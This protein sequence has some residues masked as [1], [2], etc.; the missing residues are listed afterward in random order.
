MF[1]FI[2]AAFFM[3]NFTVLDSETNQPVPNVQ[4][5]CLLHQEGGTTDKSGLIELELPSGRH[6][7]KISH[8]GYH[9]RIIEIDINQNSNLPTVFLTPRVLPMPGVEVTDKIIDN[10]E[11]SKIDQ[12]AIARK[13]SAGEPDILRSL[14]FMPQIST[15]SDYSPAPAIRGI[16]ANYTQIYLDD[17]PLLNPFHVGGLFSAIDYGIIGRM[18]VYPGIV[19]PEFGETGGGL[20]QLQPRFVT[21]NATQIEQGLISTKVRTL[22]CVNSD[23]QTS[24]SARYFT[25]DLLKRIIRSRSD[26]SFYDLCWLN[27]WKKSDHLSL[28]TI[29]YFSQE[30]LPNSVDQTGDST[31]QVIT[32][33]GYQNILFNLKAKWNASKVAFYGSATPMK[34]KTD[35]NQADNLMA[36]YG[37]KLTH[38]VGLF[39]GYLGIGLSF[40]KTVLNY[41]WHFERSLLNDI[42]GGPP[43]FAF[44]D[45][46]PADFQARYNYSTM[47]LFAN[48]DHE[49]FSKLNLNLGIRLE[50]YQKNIFP[51]PRLSLEYDW[52]SWKFALAY[53]LVY[54]FLYSLK[55]KSNFE[56]YTP[57]SIR[58][59]AN[60]DETPVIE[61]LTWQVQP[62]HSN[63]DITLYYREFRQFPTYD[64]PNEQYMRSHGY[65]AGIEF[66]YTGQFMKGNW[67]FS[68]T[69][70]TSRYA[71][72]NRFIPSSQDRPHQ[73]KMNADFGP[74][75]RWRW[76]WQFQIASGYPYSKTTHWL[77]SYSDVPLWDGA[78]YDFIPRIGNPNNARYPLYHRLDVSIER[79][80]DLFGRILTGRLAVLNVYNRKNVFYYEQYYQSFSYLGES[81]VPKKEIFGNFP[82][83]PS[84]CLIFNF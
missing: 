40:E 64:W 63:L 45:N 6:R 30:E 70:G 48:F 28:E 25:L 13:I 43:Q 56:I 2:I 12:P 68:Y 33:P 35:L 23:Y 58:F 55:G 73:L 1:S 80:W 61:T 67:Q 69:L 37:I 50:N 14:N 71:R 74:A 15:G 39:K 83:L 72:R 20:I 31:E 76:G 44:F 32:K 29:V 51:M 17:A 75:G 57:F 53:G 79:D 66:S 81:N 22:L 18:N 19:P 52:H 42:F 9:S 21:R 8:I 41:F 4:V 84:I 54:Q 16:S 65:N 49:L 46:A 78:A 59:P 24:L 34:M 38:S 11:V 62:P 27:R 60:V 82:I 5:V 3:V 47:A 10:Y 36:K 26:Y 7:L 77:P